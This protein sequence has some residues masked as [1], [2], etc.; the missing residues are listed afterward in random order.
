MSQKEA[1]YV[2]PWLWFGKRYRV[3]WKILGIILFSSAVTLILYCNHFDYFFKYVPNSEMPYVI[4]GGF[5]IEGIMNTII[6]KLFGCKP[7]CN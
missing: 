1:I 5:L 2:F 6:L 4:G 7:E 3:S